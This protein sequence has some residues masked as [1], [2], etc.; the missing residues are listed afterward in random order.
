MW[1]LSVGSVKVLVFLPLPP[2]WSEM[3]C[4]VTYPRSSEEVRMFPTFF[5]VESNYIKAQPE[6][7]GG[8]GSNLTR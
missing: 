3:E 1:L 2:S 7:E 8:G 6:G 4:T 5:V